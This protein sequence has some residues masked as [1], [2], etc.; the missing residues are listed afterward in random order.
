MACAA[1]L[2]TACQAALEAYQSDEMRGKLFKY[3]SDICKLHE[4]EIGESMHSRRKRQP[5]MQLN[6]SLVYES[7]CSRGLPECSGQLKTELFFPVINAFLVE[8][9]RRFDDKNIDIMKGILACHPLSNTFL[10]FSVL[11]PLADIYSLAD[12]Q[13]LEG[14]LEVAQRLF[15]DKERFSKTND[16]FLRLHSLRVAFPTLSN[17]VKIAMTI[18]VSTASCERSFSAMKRIKTYLRSTMGDQRLSDLGILSIERHLSKQV[19]F[20]RVLEQFVNKDKN[21]IVLS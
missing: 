14:E 11:K 15:M 9:R 1:T 17:L 21:R 10:S 7:S 20:D 18:A 19:L 8:L 13:T 3:I 4:I 2:V 5:P 12:S 16:V 6:D